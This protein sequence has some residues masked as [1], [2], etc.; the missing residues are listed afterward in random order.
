ME[1]ELPQMPRIPNTSMT[2]PAPCMEEVCVCVT[3]EEG[4]VLEDVSRVDSSH[5]LIR[6]VA[7][8]LIVLNLFHGLLLVFVL[9][10][11][12]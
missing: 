11:M 10:T 8:V 9:V 6:R 12:D 5:V 4:V 7:A 2:M 3:D 1:R